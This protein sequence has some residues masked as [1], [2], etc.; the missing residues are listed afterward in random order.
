MRDAARGGGGADALVV[1]TPWP[2]YREVSAGEL[3]LGLQA[4]CRDRRCR[5]SL[6]AH[7]RSTPGCATRA[8]AARSRW[9]PGSSRRCPTEEVAQ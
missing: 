6:A 8:L 1:C 7:R 3:L 9:R 4:A 2:D 5:R